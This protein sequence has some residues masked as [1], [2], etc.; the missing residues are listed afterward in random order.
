MEDLPFDD[1]IRFPQ[2]NHDMEKIENLLKK[3]EKYQDLKEI[4]MQTLD[5]ISTCFDE[6]KL[7][8]LGNVYPNFRSLQE[9]MAK[10]R[11]PSPMGLYS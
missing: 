6:F 10:P 11:H 1:T 3:Q 8:E 9:E 5:Y 7:S 4:D 2:Y